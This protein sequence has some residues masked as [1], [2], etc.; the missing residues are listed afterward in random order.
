MSFA[1]VFEDVAGM[2]VFVGEPEEFVVM[3]ERGKI[4]E[5]GKEHFLDLSGYVIKADK[6]IKDIPPGSRKCYLEDEHSLEYYTSYT[7]TTCKLECS[8]KAVEEVVGCVPW[9]LPQGE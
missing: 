8:I 9:Y 5:P 4:L 3:A 2:E 1:S 7:F 6:N